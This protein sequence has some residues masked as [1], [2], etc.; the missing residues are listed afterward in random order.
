MTHSWQTYGEIQ[1]NRVFRAGWDCATCTWCV[2]HD[3]PGV[4]AYTRDT[5]R[6]CTLPAGDE[7]DCPGVQDMLEGLAE[8][9]GEFRRDKT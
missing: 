7:R 8:D 4:D 2:H 1:K 6:E 3:E 5:W 9:A